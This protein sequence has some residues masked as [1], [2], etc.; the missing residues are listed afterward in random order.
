MTYTKLIAALVGALAFGLHGALAD[1]V[2]SLDDWVKTGAL[3]LAAV[4]TWLMPNTPFLAAA[5]LWVN[6][7][8]VGAGVLVPLLAD[9]V[10]GQEWVQMLIAVLTSAGVYFVPTTA[11]NRDFRVAPN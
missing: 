7:L 4:G 11:N 6:A 3:V 8:V 5:K 1:N 10:T 2:M 9:G